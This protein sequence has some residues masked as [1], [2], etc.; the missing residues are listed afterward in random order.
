M[1][2]YAILH[3]SF[4]YVFNGFHVIVALKLCAKCGE[5]LLVHV[6]RLQ[7]NLKLQQFNYKR[8]ILQNLA[9]IVKYGSH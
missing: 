9:H 3:V 4:L 7:H 6:R 5:I 2:S 1:Y 8:L